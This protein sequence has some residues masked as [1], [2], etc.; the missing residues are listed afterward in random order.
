MNAHDVEPIILLSI[1]LKELDFTITKC[2]VQPLIANITHAVQRELR[3][4]L[5]KKYRLHED[6]VRLRCLAV[7][8]DQSGNLK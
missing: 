2:S 6:I 4:T 5:L 8:I 7:V 3:A 1:G